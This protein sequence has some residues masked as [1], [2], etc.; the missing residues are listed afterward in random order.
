MCQAR[1]AQVG[2]IIAGKDVVHEEAGEFRVRAVLPAR[3]P[4]RDWRF[5]APA[6]LG[7]RLVKRA[8]SLAFAA[9]LQLEQFSQVMAES[10]SACGV[11]PARAG[12]GPAEA[13]DAAGCPPLH[14]LRAPAPFP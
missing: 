13:I 3:T 14:V 4:A 11:L 5:C 6:K 12:A 1:Q 10:G 9:H 7:V 8:P 2:D